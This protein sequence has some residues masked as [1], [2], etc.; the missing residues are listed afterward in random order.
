MDYDLARHVSD[1]V[2]GDKKINERNDNW[3]AEVARLSGEIAKSIETLGLANDEQS[4]GMFM[5]E[6]LEDVRDKIE[7]EDKSYMSRDVEPG[8]MPNNEMGT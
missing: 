4:A 3:D 8:G 1:K 6:V 7:L 5:D 2:N